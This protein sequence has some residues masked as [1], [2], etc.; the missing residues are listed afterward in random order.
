MAGNWV[1]NAFGQ[2]K[3]ALHRKLH[4]PEGQPIPTAKLEAA[5][6]KGGK[7]AK[8]AQLALTARHFNH[9]KKG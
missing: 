1:K 7:L 8:E 5:V 9:P 3:G 6:K 2:N 4:V